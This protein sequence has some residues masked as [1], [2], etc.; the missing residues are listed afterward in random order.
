M[1]VTC[2]AT[3]SR[4]APPAARDRAGLFQGVH[5][6][7]LP[8]HVGK[9]LSSITPQK[10]TWGQAVGNERAGSPK[11]ASF[12]RHSMKSDVLIRVV[13]FLCQAQ[14]TRTHLPGSTVLLPFLFPVF[15]LKTSQGNRKTWEQPLDSHGYPANSF[16]THSH[17]HQFPLM[18]QDGGQGAIPA[19]LGSPHC[20]SSS[21]LYSFIQGKQGN[22]PDLFLQGDTSSS[23]VPSAP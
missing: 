12:K 18:V 16:S 22:T 3:P 13:A 1:T 23:Q 6:L 11:R 17:H 5:P 10:C 2:A 15:S 8:L 20:L 4:A 21:I 19:V 14:D 9:A 7:P